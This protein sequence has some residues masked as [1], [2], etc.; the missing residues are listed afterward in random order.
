MWKILG[1]EALYLDIGPTAK[2]RM[3]E[4]AGEGEKAD[5]FRALMKNSEVQFLL[6]GSNEYNTFYFKVPDE[7]TPEQ[8]QLMA[9]VALD[10]V[11]NSEAPMVEVEGVEQRFLIIFSNNKEPE[12]LGIRKTPGMSSGALFKPIFEALDK[13]GRLNHDFE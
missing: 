1:K 11:K 4:L 6:N 7:Y 3:T 9:D 2:E 5:E 12:L 13:P 8:I 10:I